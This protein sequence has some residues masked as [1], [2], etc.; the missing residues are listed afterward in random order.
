MPKGESKQ[1]LLGNGADG[2]EYVKHLMSFSRFME[3]KGY[4]ADL[5]VASKVTLSATTALKK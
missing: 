2:E 3:K 5:E 4:E 1:S